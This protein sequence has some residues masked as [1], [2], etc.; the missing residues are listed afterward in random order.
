MRSN[1]FVTQRVVFA[2]K[3]YLS[4]QLRDSRSYAD[5]TLEVT[6]DCLF[7]NVSNNTVMV[8]FKE[9]SSKDVSSV[10][11]TSGFYYDTEGNPTKTTRERLNGLLDALG[12][13]E[14]IPQGVRIYVDKEYGVCYLKHEENKV[15][16]GKHYSKFVHLTPSKTDFIYKTDEQIKAEQEA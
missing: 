4:G 3:N 5:T 12:D 13:E 10:M 15:P 14:I 6:E 11:V 2:L 1:S 9:E 16:I 7:V 8:V